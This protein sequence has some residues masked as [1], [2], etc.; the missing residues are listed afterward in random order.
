MNFLETTCGKVD[1]P[2]QNALGIQLFVRFI[3]VESGF[4]A[5]FPGNRRNQ[6]KLDP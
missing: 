5:Y 2:P 3:R 4:A 1:S 6:G